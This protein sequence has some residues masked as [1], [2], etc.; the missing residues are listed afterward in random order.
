MLL[1]LPPPIIQSLNLEC[2]RSSFVSIDIKRD[3]LIDP[4][5]SGNK[6]F[7]LTE[8]LSEFKNQNAKTLITFGG[9]YSNH[10]HAT[11][12]VGKQLDI[13]TVGFI[14]AEAHELENLTPTLQDCKKWGMQLEPVSRSEYKLK[15]TSDYILAVSKKYERPYWVPEG[16]SGQLGVKG[17]ERILE[18]VDQSQY[19]VIVAA[20]GT[21]TTLSGI[22]NAS[23]PHI[24]VMGVPVLKGA[25][26]MFDEVASQLTQHNQNWD[27]ALDYHFGGYGK[28]SRELTDF[29]SAIYAE[30]K[31]PL[32]LIYT[33]KAFYALIDLIKR[34]EIKQGGRV[35]FIHTGGLQGN[36]STSL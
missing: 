3:D 20:C 36:R 21:G 4:V 1:D 24:R 13:K 30:A 26:W 32:D 16:G 11:A 12:Y 35:L 27:L 19:D 34:G 23:E 17:A 29:V 5:V 2:L 9:A 6:L 7:K 14:R 8:H 28:W 33:G 22:I 15:Q 25:S 10:L 18:G 31:L